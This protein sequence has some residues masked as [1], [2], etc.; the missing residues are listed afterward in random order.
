MS[1]RTK[2]L[3]G[4]THYFLPSDNKIIE[5][6]K[7]NAEEEQYLAEEMEGES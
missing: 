2:E 3:E 6:E 4:T 1:L 7:K 5:E